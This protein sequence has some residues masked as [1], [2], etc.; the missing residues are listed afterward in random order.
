[1]GARTTYFDVAFEGANVR[2]ITVKG[3]YQY[4]HGMKLR[5][6]GIDTTLN[7]ASIQM[8]FSYAD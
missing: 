3:L 4:D 1:M 2:K 7:I 8:Q 5:A 6:S